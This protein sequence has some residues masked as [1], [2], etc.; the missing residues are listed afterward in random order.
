[1][2]NNTIHGLLTWAGCF[3]AAKIVP[4]IPTLESLQQV[5]AILFFLAG[6]VAAIYGVLKKKK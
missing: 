6:A 5:A 2:D 3:V 4:H 1:M